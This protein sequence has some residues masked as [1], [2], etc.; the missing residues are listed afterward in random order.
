MKLGEFE[1]VPRLCELLKERGLTQLQ[2]QDLSGVPQAS[3]SRFDTNRRHEAT[4]LFAISKALG[5]SIE[6]LFVV[7]KPSKSV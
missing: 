3:I 5:V 7:K 6:D 4:H 2:L 1:V